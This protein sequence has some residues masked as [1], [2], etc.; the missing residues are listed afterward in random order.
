M[1]FLQG[2]YRPQGRFLSTKTALCIHNIAYQGRFRP[3]VWP[4]MGLP[5]NL[6]PLFSFED[7]YP[8]VSSSLLVP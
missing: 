6:K 2:V 5:D 4:H 1:W 8:R 7:G 3:D